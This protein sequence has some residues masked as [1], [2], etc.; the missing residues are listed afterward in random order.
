[1]AETAL[2]RAGGPPTGPTYAD[3]G[4]GVYLVD[5]PPDRPDRSDRPGVDAA[6]RESVGL[7]FARRLDPTF[8]VDARDVTGFDGAVFDQAGQ[9]R[10]A[11]DEAAADGFARPSLRPR[12]ARADRRS[13][14]AWSEAR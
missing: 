14:P 7:A 4:D 10:V 2:T 11:S 12:A 5:L 8:V 13:G 9:L 1:M 6:A 3:L